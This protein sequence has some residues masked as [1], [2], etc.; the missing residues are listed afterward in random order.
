MTVI[1]LTHSIHAGM[2]VYPG[3]ESPRFSTPC[4]IAQNGFTERKITLFS[5]TGTHMDAPAHII[6]GARTLDQLS[7]DNFCGQACVVDLKSMNGRIIDIA[8]LKPCE[9]LMRQVDFVLLNTGWSDLWNDEGY[10]K[11]YPV[12]SPEAAEWISEF[13]LK[14]LGT[15]MISVDREGTPD[16]PVHRILLEQNILIIENLTNLEAL[17]R[18]IFSFSCFPLKFENADGSPVRAIAVVP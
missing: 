2:P 10:F 9:D 15:D 13:G 17:P 6:H 3:T 18:V 11:G 12:L 7:V 5:H 16:F 1:D 4:T 14:G 8:V